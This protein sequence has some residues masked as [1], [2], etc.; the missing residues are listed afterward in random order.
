MTI[1]TIFTVAGIAVLALLGFSGISVRYAL[2]AEKLVGAGTSDQATLSVDTASDT[3]A[4]TTATPAAPAQAQQASGISPSSASGMPPATTPGGA[5]E[6][7][8]PAP[9]PALEPGTRRALGEMLNTSS[10]GLVEETRGGVT[11][12]DLQGRFRTAPVATVDDEGNVHITDYS[13]LPPAPDT[14]AEPTPP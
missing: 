13:H 1:K 7:P 5:V 4:P 12:I 8:Q 9:V 10:E 14:P 3:T 11:S 6:T 2:P